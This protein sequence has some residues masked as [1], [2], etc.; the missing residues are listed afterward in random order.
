MEVVAELSG[1]DEEGEEE[2][3]LHVVPCAG[4]SKHRTD[5]VDGALYEF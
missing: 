3:L 5:E 4:V 1:D 2:L